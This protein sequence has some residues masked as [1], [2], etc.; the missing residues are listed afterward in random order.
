MLLGILGHTWFCRILRS[1]RQVA[2]SV[3][4][5]DSADLRTNH[6]SVMTSHRSGRNSP[7]RSQG[8]CVIRCSG[9]RSMADRGIS[10]RISAL[11]VTSQPPT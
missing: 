11:K 3:S 6:G 1:S 9:P 2:R 8:L 5:Y 4:L 7:S 10:E